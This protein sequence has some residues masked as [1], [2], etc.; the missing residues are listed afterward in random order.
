MTLD[1]DALP[2]WSKAKLADYSALNATP[3]PWPSAKR[4]ME[5][6]FG[7]P[8][9]GG[10]VA[11]GPFVV[12]GVSD[13]P[14]MSA[15]FLLGNPLTP[16]GD[17]VVGLGDDRVTLQLV[18]G[19]ILPLPDGN[20]VTWTSPLPPGQEGVKTI[21]VRAIRKGDGPLLGLSE[22]ASVQEVLAE[23]FKRMDTEE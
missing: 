23:A 11:W 21:T 20:G 13:E 1:D 22:S 3:E 4:T 7:Y 14:Y 18:K 6:H 16:S 8:Q 19:R 15:M 2:E 12:E 17:R 9:N 10:Y 5:T